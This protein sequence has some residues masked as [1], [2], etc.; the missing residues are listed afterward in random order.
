MAP[1]KVGVL[2]G[3]PNDN[4]KV[5]AALAT[6]EFFGLEADHRVLSAHRNH[7]KVVELVKPARANGYSAF[8]ASAGMANHLAGVVAALTTLP[9][10]GLPLPVGLLDGLDSL[11]ST[12]Q[13]P[14]G[15]PVGT[16]GVGVAMNAALQVVRQLAVNDDEL[17]AKLQDFA[18]NGFKSA[19]LDQLIKQK[20]IEFATDK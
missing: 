18:D 16:V 13:M 10:V 7:D 17:T 19:E 9:V 5:A 20:K 4:P 15:V 8:I 3:S 14:P 1:Y 12:V 11:L 2:N 6:L